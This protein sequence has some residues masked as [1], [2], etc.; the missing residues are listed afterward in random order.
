VWSRNKANLYIRD[1]LDDFHYDPKALPSPI[2]QRKI[3]RNKLM[4]TH[5]VGF[6]GGGVALNPER[7]YLM[8]GSD[9]LNIG[10]HADVELGAGDF[11]VEAW[12]RPTSVEYGGFILYAK[13]SGEQRAYN[14]YW[15][16]YN[17]KMAMTWTTTGANATSVERA[18]DATVV[19]N[20]TWSHLEWDRSGDTLYFFHDG[21][22]RG[23]G[24]MTGVTVFQGTA[25]LQLGNQGSGSGIIGN[26]DE[27]RIS[28][29]ARHTAGFTPASVEH[30]SDAN[31]MVLVHCHET[32]ASGT[33]G[34]GATF[35]ESG[36]TGHTVT[37]NG[38]AIR[39]NTIF[40]F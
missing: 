5:L 8:D 32:I 29:T 13:W 35:V 38:N 25:G 15:A 40:K 3:Y 7:S 19:S 1:A 33:T 23:T 2:A 6:G 22:E 4:L 11:C 9:W 20:D 12:V 30:T 37:E 28:D 24:D 26:V 36:N 31:T 34:S 17:N 27:W 14:F 39:D 21:V 18:S 16:P 10:D